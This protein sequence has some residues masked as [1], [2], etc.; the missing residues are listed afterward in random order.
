VAWF[1]GRSE[2]GP[3]ALGNRSILARPDVTGLKDKLNKSIKFRESFRP[4]GCSV[5]QEKAHLYFDIDQNFNNPYMSF[6]I[7]VREEHKELLKEVSH[8]DGTSRMQTVKIGQNEKFYRL[9]E[10]F[11]EK[12]GLPCLLNT[13]LNVMDEP[14]VETIQDVRRFMEN[15]PTDYLVINDFL[16]KRKDLQK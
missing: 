1:Q 3:R 5:I 12:S 6:A 7:K 13:S 4:Y 11:G 8:I 9:L 16:I 10:R 14:I 2:S 15:T